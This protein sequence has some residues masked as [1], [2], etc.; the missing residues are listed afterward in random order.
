LTSD[1][2]WKSVK[3]HYLFP[4][5]V[6][7]ALYQGKM[8]S[9][10]WQGLSEGKLNLPDTISR[11]D[12]SRSF[13]DLA[14]KK[15]NVRIQ[16]PY[17]HGRGVMKYL[18]NYVK[19]GPISNH[20]ILEVDS[21]MVEFGYRDHRDGKHKSQRLATKHFIDR[22]LDHVA[23][24]RQHVIRHYGLYGHQSQEK[25][26]FCR[27]HLGQSPEQEYQAMTWA[28]FVTQ[29]SPDKA[30]CCSQC[31]KPLVRGVALAKNSINR[32]PGRCSVQQAVRVDV[33]T[34]SLE[35]MVPPKRER[36]FFLAKSTP[37]N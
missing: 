26:N 12:Q 4:V 37:L 34:W 33:E 30:G 3:H 16:P 6:V 13:K 23:E 17:T 9:A 22:V 15:W 1:G 20:R 14:K 32:V 19:G 24:P 11:A 25:R 35:K 10:L 28:D 2:E 31:G 5:Q 27:K 7:R 21:Q 18:A 36:R 8:L 29:R